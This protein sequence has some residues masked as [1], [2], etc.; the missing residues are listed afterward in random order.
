MEAF[1]CSFTI[2]IGRCACGLLAERWHVTCVYG[3]AAC[4]RV[5]VG[6]PETAAAT[7]RCL[8]L[9]VPDIWPLPMSCLAHLF[10]LL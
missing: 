4:M 5:R 9:S 3:E 1:H 2:S 10:L 7:N 8:I 6:W